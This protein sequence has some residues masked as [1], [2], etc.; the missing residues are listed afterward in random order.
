MTQPDVPEVQPSD[1]PK[2]RT[3]QETK[4]FIESLYSGKIVPVFKNACYSC[5]N[6]RKVAAGLNLQR[7]K[8]DLVTPASVEIWQRVYERVRDGEMPPPDAVPPAGLPVPPVV[9]EPIPLP[10]PRDFPGR[11]LD[12]DPAEENRPGLE[13]AVDQLLEAAKVKYPEMLA[14][15][16]L[17][18]I[19][20]DESSVQR[21]QKQ[22]RNN[23]LRRFQVDQIAYETAR[24]GIE[25]LQASLIDLINAD[26]AL[27]ATKPE[28][29]SSL[30]KSVTA[31]RMLERSAYARWEHG[32][33]DKTSFL[34]AK[35]ARLQAQIRL[36]AELDKK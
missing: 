4:A 10:A 30:T 9:D 1:Q 35:S 8:P 28:R 20:G 32:V 11:G 12:V 26:L 15:V 29:V 34:T 14:A 3:P 18:V 33:S 5:H 6:D 2:E 13:G 27:A 21:L 36:Q 31:H 22:L 7:L 19:R 23:A 16:P 17:L 25:P 24:I